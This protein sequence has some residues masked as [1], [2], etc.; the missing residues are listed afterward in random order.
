[1]ITPTKGIAADR[2]LLTLG[3]QMLRLLDEPMSVSGLWRRLELWRAA[4][5]HRSALS[6]AWFVL[7]LDVLYA[8]R[9]IDFVDG[10]IAI[11]RGERA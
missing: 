1:M 4:N 8:L 10:E 11:A 6:Y 5:G 9:L 7:G 2:A 3:A